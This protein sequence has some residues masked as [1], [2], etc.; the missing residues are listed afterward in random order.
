MSSNY[1]SG[2]ADVA[3]AQAIDS[4]TDSYFHTKCGMDEWWA[5]NLN[6]R[7]LVTEVRIQNRF[8]GNTS[9]NKRLEGA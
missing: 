6:N 7:F 5:A 2:D 4:K 3:A 8:Q 1:R 9:S